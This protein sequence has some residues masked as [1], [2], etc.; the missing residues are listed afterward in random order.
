M[1]KA[2][3]ISFR[4]DKKKAQVLRDVSIEVSPGY[5]TVVLGHNGGGKSTLFKLLYGELVPE[6]GK[7]WTDYSVK[8]GDGRNKEDKPDFSTVQAMRQKVAFVS[9]D[10]PLFE[11]FDV[12]GNVELFK[13]LYPDFDEAEF[14]KLLEYLA[15]D[16]KP[17]KYFKELSTGE[18]MKL[19]IAFALARKPEIIIMDEPFANLDPV[20]KTDIMELLHERITGENLG[21]LVSTHLLEEINDRADYIYVLENGRITK[22]GDRESLFEKEGADSLRGLLNH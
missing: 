20:V 18:Y 3:N 7:I 10:S 4:Y 14:R 1:I 17:G 16:I 2:D 5:L 9:A 15:L 11:S 8:P 21:V 19:R 12:T 22:S 6:E 13:A